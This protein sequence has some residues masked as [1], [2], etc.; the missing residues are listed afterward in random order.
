VESPLRKLEFNRISCRIAVVMGMSMAM[1]SRQM[2]LWAD[3]KNWLPVYS[4]L[5][6][7]CG[8]SE[9]TLWKSDETARV[10]CLLISFCRASDSSGI[11]CHP[12]HVS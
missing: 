9:F 10:N 11:V 7:H 6:S 12:E 1:M 5:V 8:Y 3:I 4:V 2:F